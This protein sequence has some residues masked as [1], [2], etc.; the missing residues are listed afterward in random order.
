MLVEGP[1]V[2]VTFACLAA[3]LGLGGVWTQV[4]SNPEQ[5]APVLDALPL[6]DTVT[7]IFSARSTADAKTTAGDSLSLQLSLWKEWAMDG[8]GRSSAAWGILLTLPLDCLSL[9]FLC[10][11]RRDAFNR[12]SSDTEAQASTAT[13]MT[14]TRTSTSTAADDDRDSPA[15]PATSSNVEEEEDDTEASEASGKWGCLSKL[16]LEQAAG[17][18]AAVITTASPSPKSTFE[19][20]SP[21]AQQAGK[22]RSPADVKAWMARQKEQCEVVENIQACVETDAKACNTDAEVSSPA[23]QVETECVDEAITSHKSKRR[24]AGELKALMEKKRDEC[25]V[26]ESEQEHINTDAKA[27]DTP[28][29]PSTAKNNLVIRMGNASPKELQDRMSTLKNQCAI[30]ES[31]PEYVATDAKSGNVPTQSYSSPDKENYCA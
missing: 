23:Q 11:R 24:G 12:R 9:Y 16:L 30:S 26:L 4:K 15:S 31:T 18:A 21:A 28:L 19:D 17:E 6:P 20:A 13:L 10:R 25:H 22:M 7:G 29:K 3:S 8:L 14:S 27:N 2:R 1:A 5:L